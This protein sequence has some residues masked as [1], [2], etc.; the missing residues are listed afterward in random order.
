M[1]VSLSGKIL[2]CDSGDDGFDYHTPDFSFVMSR[3]ND[4][5]YCKATGKSYNHFVPVRCVDHPQYD[6]KSKV[7][8]LCSGCNLMYTLRHPTCDN[9]WGTG[10]WGGEH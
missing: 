1:G 6:G 3:K 5:K 10:K 9:C 4:C 2:D 8:R 7:K